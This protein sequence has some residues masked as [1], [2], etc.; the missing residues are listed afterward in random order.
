MLLNIALLSESALGLKRAGICKTADAALARLGRL[1]LHAAGR[2]VPRGIAAGLGI[3]TGCLGISA[4][5]LGISAGCLGIPAGCLG[6]CARSLRVSAGCL[7]VGSGSLSIGIRLRECGVLRGGLLSK[8]RGSRLTISVLACLR[9]G[10]RALL[11]IY[12]WIRIGLLAI[13]ILFH[14]CSFH[15]QIKG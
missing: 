5:C 4:G 6:E 8:S 12:V 11:C 3:S 14:M 2:N 1:A 9:V 7:K 15:W 10:R 13:L